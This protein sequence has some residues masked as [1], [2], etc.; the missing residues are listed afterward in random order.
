MV[1]GSTTPGIEVGWPALEAKS[2][3]DAFRPSASL[4]PGGLTWTLSI[5]WPQDYEACTTH[6]VHGTRNDWWPAARPLSVFKGGT[7]VNWDR[8]ASGGPDWWK[9]RGF[10]KN[11]GT[12]KY[13]E[14]DKP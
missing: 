12:D 10:F 4:Q 14:I 3:G 5:P 11:D 9:G 6:E 7:Q 8:S 1:G 2:W 13:E